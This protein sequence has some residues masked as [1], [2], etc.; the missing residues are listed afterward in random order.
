MA[1]I[2]QDCGSYSEKDSG[3][4]LDSFNKREERKMSEI[5]D[6]IV[7]RVLLFGHVE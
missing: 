6:I 2:V 3:N 4:K 5:S 7:V 1:E